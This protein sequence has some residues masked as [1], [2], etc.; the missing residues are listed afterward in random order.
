MTNTQLTEPE[1]AGRSGPLPSPHWW[2]SSRWAAFAALAMALIAT[3]VA[4]A[5]WFRPVESASPTF[6]GQQT[7]QAKS[8]VC[9]AYTAVHQGVVKNTHLADPNPRDPVGQLAIA[10]NAR[11]ALLGGGAYLRD[12]VAAQPATPPDLA[13]AV[14]S[15][16][17]TIEQLG[18]GYLEAATSIVLDPLRHD[19]DSEVTQLNAL[20]G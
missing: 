13:Q 18:V 17:N 19:L 10:A 16:G 6:T 4:V 8:N 5:A 15:M 20:C 3:A 1:V 2:K 9:S 14:N 12:R 7:A 11:L